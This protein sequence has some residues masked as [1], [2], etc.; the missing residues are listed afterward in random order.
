MSPP[1]ARIALPIRPFLYT[2][3]QVAAM[4]SVREDTLRE[5]YLYF[6]GRSTG[7]RVGKMTARNI[8][9]DTAPPDWRIAEHV[10][11]NYLKSKGFT[12]YEPR[13]RG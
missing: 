13:V 12:V 10:F 9:P 8:A 11:R 4:L 7:T 3:D 2:L 6:E 5:Q 1:K